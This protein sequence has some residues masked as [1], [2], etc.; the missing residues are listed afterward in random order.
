[1]NKA[2]ISLAQYR[3]QRAQECL[4]DARLLFANGKYNST[5]NRTYYAAFYGVRALLAL[6]GLDAAK[7]AGVISL[8]NRE[9]VKTG[10]LRADA[11]RTLQ[12]LF[13]ARTEGD[14]KDLVMVEKAQ[15]RTLLDLAQG[16]V[17][18]V[19]ELLNK[20]IASDK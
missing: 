14:Y 18:D 1:M 20:Q 3:I 8:F 11:G 6:K 19:S 4:E 12:R 2:R 16:F 13:D 7:H 10:L 9:Y 15:A 5:V 17:T